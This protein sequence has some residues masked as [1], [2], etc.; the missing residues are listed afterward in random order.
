MRFGIPLGLVHPDAWHDLAV[1]ADELGFDSVWLPEHLVLATGDGM[2]GYPGGRAPI[3]PSTPLYDA[4]VRL[5][6][7]AAATRGVRLGTAV[8]LLGLRHP[9]VSA[10]AFATLDGIAGGRTVLGA[11]AGWY[12]AEWDAVGAPFAERGA[13]LDE[14]IGV[15]RRLWSEEAVAHGGPHFPFPE[16]A[17][18]PKPPRRAVPI[19]IGGES[20]AALRRAARNDGWISMPAPPVRVAGAAAELRRLRAEAGRGAEP[21]EVVAHAEGGCRPDETAAWTAAG[22]HTLIVR[23]WRRGREAVAAV[24]RFARDHGLLPR[25]ASAAPAPPP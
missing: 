14:A 22:V 13:R 20:P 21:F 5:A 3:R 8:Y 12:R 7:L 24:E 11:G 2:R 19:L 1:V 18:E 9:L 17:F 25:G 6:A 16:V 15:L 4:P 10:R 23:P